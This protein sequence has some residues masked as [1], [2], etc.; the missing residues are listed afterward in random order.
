M[1]RKKKESKEKDEDDDN[2][3][4]ETALDYEEK[5]LKRL[6]SIKLTERR[7]STNEQQEAER[8]SAAT[9]KRAVLQN[10]D[11]ILD[12]KLILLVNDKSSSDWQL[13]SIKLTP[14][15]I[16]LRNVIYSLY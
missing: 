16:S 6:Q 4:I 9:N 3:V 1:A 12:R 2:I 10:V 13:P 5:S 15:D 8:R 7:L 14:S 11:H